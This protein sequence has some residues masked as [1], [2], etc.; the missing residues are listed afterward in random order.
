MQCACV[1]IHGKSGYVRPSAGVSALFTSARLLVGEGVK[2]KGSFL[3]SE[4]HPAPLL[5][6]RRTDEA[7]AAGVVDIARPAFLLLRG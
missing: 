2:K 7:K 5:R 3:L 4:L 1:Y 6:L